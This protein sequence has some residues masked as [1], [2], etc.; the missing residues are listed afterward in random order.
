MAL[1]EAGAGFP[2]VLLAEDAGF[3]LTWA[4]KVLT[5][6]VNLLC[7]KRERLSIEGMTFDIPTL[8]YGLPAV[9]MA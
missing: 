5:S 8:E 2:R 3:L 6:Y 1:K 7:R 9:G 4:G